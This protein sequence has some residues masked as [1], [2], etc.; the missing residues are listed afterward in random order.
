MFATGFD[1]FAAIFE[2]FADLKVEVATNPEKWIALNVSILAPKP[3]FQPVSSNALLSRTPA[4]P[5]NVAKQDP[6]VL[7]RDPIPLPTLRG[8]AGGRLQGGDRVQFFQVQ[9]SAPFLRSA[10]TQV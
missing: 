2:L 6:R 7:P 1:L 8:G 9:K 5:L 3:L 4:P 10:W